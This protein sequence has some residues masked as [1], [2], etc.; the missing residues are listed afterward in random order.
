MWHWF[1]LYKEV[2][3]LYV[4]IYISSL[5]D[6]LSIF[7]YHT[8]LGHSV[9]CATQSF[10]LAI[11]HKVVYMSILNASVHCSTIYNS[12]DLEAT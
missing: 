1:L 3:Q 11:S 7:P 10:P 12:Q 4:C 5:L 8:P 9:P 6:L 2:N